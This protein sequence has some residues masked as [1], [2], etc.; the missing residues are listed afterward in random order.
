MLH[1]LVPV[2]ADHHDDHRL[3]NEVSAMVVR[4]PIGAATPAE[5]LRPVARAERSSK[6]RDQAPATH[7]LLS[8]LDAWPPAAVRPPAASCTTSPSSTSW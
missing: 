8:S 7:L 4:L 6:E 5:R 2:G 1:V 3:G